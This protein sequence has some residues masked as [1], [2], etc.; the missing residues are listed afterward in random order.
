MRRCIGCAAALIGA[1]Q[2]RRCSTCRR[3]LN[4][5]LGRARTAA[6]SVVGRTLT[7]T[8]RVCEVE[9][10]WVQQETGRRRRFCDAHQHGR[11][12]GWDAPRACRTC[13]STFVPRRHGQLRCPEHPP[14]PWSERKATPGNRDKN[15]RR[16]AALRMLPAERIDP[17]R[18]YERDG[19]ICGL[20]S[21]AVD[22]AL[23]YPDPYSASLDH[24]MPLSRGGH[25][26]YANVQLAHLWCNVAKCD[27]VAA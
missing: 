20:C 9:F 2:R 8:C 17:Q 23:A 4:A 26:T 7:A 3:A 13:G 5:S 21:V 11:R 19:W 16:R 18:V 1:P 27:R 24:I 25:H 10:S 12:P 22:P 15:A 14:A 6:R